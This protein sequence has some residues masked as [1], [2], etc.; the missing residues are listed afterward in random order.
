MGTSEALDCLGEICTYSDPSRRREYGLH[1]HMELAR[2]YA[3][4]NPL[5]APEFYNG[6]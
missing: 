5:E 2:V 1:I 3:R 4:S 6:F